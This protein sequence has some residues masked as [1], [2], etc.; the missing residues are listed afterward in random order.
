MPENMSEE[1]K[2]LIHAL[3]AELQLTPAEASI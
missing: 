1:C 2:N 3:G